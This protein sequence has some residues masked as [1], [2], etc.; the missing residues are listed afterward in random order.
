MTEVATDPRY[1]ECY[2]D[3]HFV[4]SKFGEWDMCEKCGATEE[5][6]PDARIEDFYEV[7]C[8][9][10]DAVYPEIRGSQAKQ[11]PNCGNTDVLKTVYLEKLT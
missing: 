3:D 6:S 2:C 9:E 5:D 1:W 7:H 11:C 4:H 10:C 8:L